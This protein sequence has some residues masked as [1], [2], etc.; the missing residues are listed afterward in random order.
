MVLKCARLPQQ[1]L[2]GLA[3]K[4]TKVF[5][6][7]DKQFRKLHSLPSLPGGG[8]DNLRDNVMSVLI[9]SGLF[10]VP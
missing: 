6:K 2:Y 4:I 9:N 3:T 1:D 8:Y 10:E 7:S 5:V